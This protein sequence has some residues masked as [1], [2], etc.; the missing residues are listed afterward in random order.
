MNPKMSLLR[1][2]VGKYQGD[3]INH[4]SQ[5]FVGTF[6]LQT[7]LGDAGFQIQFEARSES[8]PSLLFHSEISTVASNARGGICLFNLN[9]NMPFLAEHELVE[10]KSNPEEKHLIFRFGNVA[11][12]SSFREE[13]HLKLFADAIR[14]EYHWGMPGGDFAYRSGALMKRT[15]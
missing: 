4:E 2:A 9:T 10:E 5:K 7:L 13:I 15:K 6:D 8:D 12:R 3:G 11:D 1:E 14:Y